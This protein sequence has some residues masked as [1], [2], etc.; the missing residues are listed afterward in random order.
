[1]DLR[2]LYKLK[3]FILYL[4][5]NITKILDM[6]KRGRKFAKLLLFLLA[7]SV[8]YCFK[9]LFESQDDYF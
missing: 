9:H 1:M 8:F 4:N 3:L 5:K 2:Y 6:F 7:D